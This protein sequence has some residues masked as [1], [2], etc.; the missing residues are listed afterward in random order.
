M[1]TPA[2]EFVEPSRGPDAESVARLHRIF[3]EDQILV[4]GGG[5]HGNALMLVPPL[6][7]DEADLASGLDRIIALIGR[8]NG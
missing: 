6:I 5:W 3:L 8:D 4:Y 7:I 1:T 2:V